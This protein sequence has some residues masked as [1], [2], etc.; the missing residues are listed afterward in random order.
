MYGL[1]AKWCRLTLKSQGGGKGYKKL[2][3]DVQDD[4]QDGR[5]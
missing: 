1:T 2:N 3:Q 4:L 5:D